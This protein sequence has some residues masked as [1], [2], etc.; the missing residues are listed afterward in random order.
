MEFEHPADPV[1]HQWSSTVGARGKPRMMARGSWL[2][3]SIS[4][5][6]SMGQEPLRNSFRAPIVANSYFLACIGHPGRHRRLLTLQSPLPPKK[7]SEQDFLLARGSLPTAKAVFHRFIEKLERPVGSSYLSRFEIQ[8]LDSYRACADGGV[9]ALRG[10]DH[11][12]GRLGLRKPRPQSWAITSG[13]AKY[14]CTVPE[15]HQFEVINSR[16]CFNS[17]HQSARKE[18]FLCVTYFRRES[19]RRMINSGG[20]RFA[21]ACRWV[22]STQGHANIRISITNFQPLRRT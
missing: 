10:S 5:S 19:D 8:E 6:I 15:A 14:C 13:G 18:G 4:I 17:V 21:R 16:L 22:L 1:A 3:I 20:E 2:R 9:G 7:D 12:F 11:P